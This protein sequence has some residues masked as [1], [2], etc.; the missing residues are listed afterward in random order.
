MCQQTVD[1]F[2]KFMGLLR[3]KE[4]YDIM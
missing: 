1:T 3:K 4:S 2:S